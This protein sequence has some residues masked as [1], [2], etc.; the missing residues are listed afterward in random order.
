MDR[1]RIR[2]GLYAY[3]CAGNESVISLLVYTFASR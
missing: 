3:T 1:W 2:F